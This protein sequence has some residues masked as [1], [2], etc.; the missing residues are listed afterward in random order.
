M[1]NLV[2]RNK[3]NQKINHLLSF[4]ILVCSLILFCSACSTKPD[5][6]TTVEVSGEYYDWTKTKQPEHPW[7]HDYNKTLVSKIL[8]C[9]R[10]GEGNVDNVFLTFEQTLETIRKL[11][12]ITLGIPKIAY[13][14][15]WQYNGHDSKYPAWDEVNNHL[16]RE[17]DT[18]A[19]ESLQWLIK[20]AKDYN[21]TISFHIN[22]IDAFK[23]SPLWSEYLKK[24]IIAKDLQGVLIKGEGFNGMQSYQ[25]SYAR[26]WNL[27][28][29]QKRI[30]R[31]IEMIPELKEIGTIH[32]DAY[33]SMRPNGVGEPI[34][35]YLGITMDEEISAQRKIYRYWRSKGIDVTNEAGMYWLRKDPFLGLQGLSWHHTE[36]NYIKENWLHKP[37]NF[38]SLPLALSGYT[39]MQCEEEIRKDSEN[40]SGL[41][42]QVC[43]NL[44]P[45]YYKRNP[46][47]SKYSNVI[48]TD[49][50]VI[51][52]VLWEK[53]TLIAYSREK[54]ITDMKFRLPSTWG[55]VTEVQIF[56][57]TIEGINPLSVIKTTNMD[58]DGRAF[59][60]MIHINIKKGN[61][62]VFKPM[63]STI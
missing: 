44:V 54:D 49:D 17:E 1:K 23:D 41:L 51:C 46:D 47:V 11:D 34:S 2:N 33:H 15:G 56:E 20:A 14:V 4:R 45:W 63:F 5:P 10:D 22:M 21:T 3:E 8:L 31:L 60:K 6:T 59:Y 48:I 16:K 28:Y 35:P 29:A 27:G 53:T 57:L 50:M 13:L 26:E 12:N 43:L 58:G 24:D 61:P 39:P 52:P 25:I 32:I 30:D 55:D 38:H 19:L 36:S 40:L 18:T 9:T 7:N 42:E 62:V 37:E